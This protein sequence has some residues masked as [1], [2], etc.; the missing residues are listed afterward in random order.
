M[1][2]LKLG[3]SVLTD[4]SGYKKARPAM[5][6]KL[7]DAVARIWRKGIRDIVLVHG[8]GSFG[9]APVI[10]HGLKNGIT[11]A[12][13]K[14]GFADTHASCSGLSLMLV[15]ALIAVSIPPA[16]IITLE[17][18]RIARFDTKIV[19]DYL[20]G[21]YLPVLFGD[22]VPDSKLGGYPCSGDQIVS[23]LG[24][25]AEIVV[26]ATDVDGVLDERG[27]VISLINKSNIK[28]V[29]AHLRHTENDVTGGMKGK[30][31]ELLG[32]GTPSYILNAAKPERIDA[33]LSG[34]PAICT[35]I[36]G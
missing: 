18:R 19:N 4:K 7:A 28:E 17:N 3:G 29:S 8:A 2:V 12:E 25:G 10:K 15:E 24:K 36:E 22:M 21:G 31:E 13:Q 32:L 26:L 30:I 5:I 16:V 34:K 11:S 33:I 6:K 27:E 9:H 23:Y 20:Q 14:L 1:K 35:K